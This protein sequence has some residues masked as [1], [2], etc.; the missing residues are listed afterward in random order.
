[1]KVVK[2]LMA[3]VL[4][5]ALALTLLT[6]CGGGGGGTSGISESTKNTIVNKLSARQGVE[7][8]Y[9]K[10]LEAKAKIIADE[11]ESTPS[12]MLTGKSDEQQ[13][14]V[15]MLQ[16]AAGEE[17]VTFDAGQ[18]DGASFHATL[19]ESVDGII[20]IKNSFFGSAAEIEKIGIV[21]VEFGSRSGFVY[22]YEIY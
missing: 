21:S 3:L 12:S 9:D 5:S 4:A 20:S 16:M 11:I 17:K 8:Q 10:T 19:D 13:L 15:F 22:V 6:G 14:Y 1:M 7:V 18:S 2:K